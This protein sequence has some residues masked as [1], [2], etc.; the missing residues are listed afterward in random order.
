MIK[1]FG[2]F[3]TSSDWLTFLSSGVALYCTGYGIILYYMFGQIYT[4]GF[5]ET[6]T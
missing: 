6:Q 4:D 5:V 3:I 2:H 1:R